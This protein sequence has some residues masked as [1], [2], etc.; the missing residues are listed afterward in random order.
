MKKFQFKLQRLL[1]IRAAKEKEIQNELAK[2]VSLQNKERNKQKELAD[3]MEQNKNIYSD[4]MRSKKFTPSDII[5]YQH[6]VDMSLKAI[7]AD[8]QRILNLE[9]QAEEIRSRL[10]VASREKRVVEKLKER[11][12][13]E[14]MLEYNREMSKENDD[15]NQNIFNRA[16]ALE[17]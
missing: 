14:Y 11:Q 10:V 1:D 2:V 9:P 13:D 3:Q 17:I 8:E 7:E 5:M 16:K 6:F 4:K 15:M 12:Y